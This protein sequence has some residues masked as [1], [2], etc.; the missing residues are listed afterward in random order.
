VLI[1]QVG[2]SYD[3][4]W[5]AMN[6]AVEKSIPILELSKGGMRQSAFLGG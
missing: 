3:P 4:S 6:K 5:G 2:K 1:E